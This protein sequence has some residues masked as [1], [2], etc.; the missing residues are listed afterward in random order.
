MSVINVSKRSG[1]VEALDLNKFHKV[2]FWACEGL[3]GVS[4]SEVELR[5]SIQFY[6]GISTTE[7]QETLIKAAS[8]LISADTP[9]YQHVASRLINLQLRKDV[10][11]NHVPC[12]LYDHI[13]NVIRLGYYDPSILDMYSPEEIETL[14]TFINHD[15]DYNIPFV[16]MEQFRGKYAVKDRTTNKIF[17]TPQMAFILISAIIFSKYKENRLKWVKDYYD[18][19]STFDISLPTPIMA[20][21]RTPQKQYSS[22]TLIETGDSLDEINATTSSI[23]R[24]VSQKA[25]IGIGVGRIRAVG[26]RVRNG[27]AVHTGVMPFLKLFQSAVSSCSQGGVRKGSATAYYPAF[28]YEIEDLLTLKNNKGTDDSRVRHIDYA[29]QFNKVLYERLLSGSD[30][31]LF[32]PHDVPDLY[33]AFFVDTDKFRTLYEKYEADTTVRKKKIGAI[34]LFSKFVQE[35]KDTGRIYLMNVDHCNQ[36]SAFIPEKA[37]ICMSNLCLDGNSI[38]TILKEDGQII[39]AP[40]AE[41]STDVFDGDC[42]ILSRNIKTDKLEFSKVTSFAKTSSIA[43]CVKVTDEDTGRSIICTPDHLIYTKNRG[44]VMAKE[45]LTTDELYLD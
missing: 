37:P 23:V 43:K 31:T 21:L 24:Y 8:E 38:V 18:A 15:R 32:S 41:I 26:S 45:L 10:Y 17:E 16:G 1:Q 2:V 27:D 22:C 29:V 44:Y 13:H 42:K 28:H 25:G 7:I 20:G 19:I 12:H 39:D 3:T 33:E 40:L 35:R 5:S 9:N 36:H 4:A 6:D 14:N 34:D 30:I 11:G